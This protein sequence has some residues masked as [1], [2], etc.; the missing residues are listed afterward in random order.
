MIHAHLCEVCHAESPQ[1]SK[2]DPK[3]FSAQKAKRKLRE[4]RTARDGAEL[5]RVIDLAIIRLQRMPLRTLAA[6]DNLKK[7]KFDAFEIAGTPGALQHATVRRY[8]RRE[9]TTSDQ[10]R[11]SRRRDDQRMLTGKVLA[12][13]S[14]RT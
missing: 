10:W 14:K 8:I 4:G 6:A 12:L 2:R 11:T 13:D 5:A 1:E 7:V 9:P 3:W